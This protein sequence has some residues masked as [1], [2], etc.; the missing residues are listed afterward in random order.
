[1]R[2]TFEIFVKL[3]VRHAYAHVVYTESHMR[4]SPDIVL[5]KSH[6]RVSPYIV[7]GKSHMR[8]SPDVV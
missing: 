4:V 1:M 6:M 2:L 5:G 7:L 8:V 3:A